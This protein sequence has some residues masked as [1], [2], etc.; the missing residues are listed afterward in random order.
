MEAQL[1]C[2]HDAGI[3]FACLYYAQSVLV[4][5]EFLHRSS[6][7][8]FIESGLRCWLGEKIPVGHLLL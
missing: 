8:K 2:M 4:I 7:R 1:E 6:V 3:V 5:T